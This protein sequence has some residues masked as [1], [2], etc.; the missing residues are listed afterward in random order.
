MTPDAIRLLDDERRV[1]RFLGVGDRA[2]SI[3]DLQDPTANNDSLWLSVESTWRH[4]PVSS[5]RHHSIDNGMFDAVAID[6]GDGKRFDKQRF[7]SHSHASH[8]NTQCKT[9]PGLIETGLCQLHKLIFLVAHRLNEMFL[10]GTMGYAPHQAHDACRASHCAA[11][12][13][14]VAG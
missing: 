9:Y 14:G 5:G 2:E 12:H 13:A 1:D 11:L 4:Y 6:L 8:P 7:V 10:F 3:L